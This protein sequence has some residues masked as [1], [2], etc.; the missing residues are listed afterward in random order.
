MIYVPNL[1]Y[2][3]YCGKRYRHGVYRGNEFFTNNVGNIWVP[4]DS[5]IITLPAEELYFGDSDI[6][7]DA[8]ALTVAVVYN[9]E[10][11][12]V[13]AHSFDG[14]RIVEQPFFPGTAKQRCRLSLSE[15]IKDKAAVQIRRGDV[16]VE[17]YTI[18]CYDGLRERVCIKLPASEEP[19]SL[20][21]DDVEVVPQWLYQGRIWLP[22]STTVSGYTSVGAYIR[23]SEEVHS[24]LSIARWRG[25]GGYSDPFLLTE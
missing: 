20:F 16:I 18:Y 8:D 19:L 3:T 13:S 25:S 11:V 7:S 2:I 14:N 6:L 5:L 24:A 1:C 12:L 17:E 15:T 23:F 9:G 10:N 22:L 4:A 21:V